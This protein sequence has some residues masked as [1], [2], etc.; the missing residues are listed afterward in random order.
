MMQGL[1]VLLFFGLGAGAGAVHFRLLARDADL[2]VRGGPV[3]A[4]LAARFGRFALTLLVL[5]LAAKLAGWPAL[6]AAAAGFGLA[7][8]VM[9]RRLGA[10]SAGA[11]ADAGAAP[12]PKRGGGA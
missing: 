4:V 5:V 7:R 12:E 9:L 10:V 3:A 8:P 6:L 2:L 1:A 11:A